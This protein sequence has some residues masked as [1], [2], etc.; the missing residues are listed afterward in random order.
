MNLSIQPRTFAVPRELN[1]YLTHVRSDI[2][3]LF[4]IGWPCASPVETSAQSSRSS[5]NAA[6]RRTPHDRRRF[7]TA[8]GL[9]QSNGLA[10]QAQTTDQIARQDQRRRLVKTPAADRGRARLSV[11]S[12]RIG[13][14]ASEHSKIDPADEI[15]SARQAQIGI[16]NNT[17]ETLIARVSS[18]RVSSVVSQSSSMIAEGSVP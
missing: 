17:E 18:N 3:H 15:E 12:R 7:C 11:G 5:F 10:H 13:L 16:E 6:S 4:P 14:V 9:E 8:F 2:C 1:F